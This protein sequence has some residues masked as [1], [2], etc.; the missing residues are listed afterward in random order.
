MPDDDEAGPVER[1]PSRKN[2]TDLEWDAAHELRVEYS[3]VETHVGRPALRSLFFEVDAEAD[4]QLAKGPNEA[5]SR[6]KEEWAA[7]E[8][9]TE[10]E[11]IRKRNL[12][13]EEAADRFRLLVRFLKFVGFSNL[14]RAQ[15]DAPR[16]YWTEKEE[17]GA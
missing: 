8:R 5:A 12:T 11:K 1:G 13:D 2:L 14:G 9:S 3:R 17:A 15:V 4:F 10:P 16:L 7:V 6:F